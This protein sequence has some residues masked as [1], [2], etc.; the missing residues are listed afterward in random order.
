MRAASKTPLAKQ[1]RENISFFRRVGRAAFTEAVATPPV[2]LEPQRPAPPPHPGLGRQPVDDFLPG[3]DERCTC[4]T[5]AWCGA[6]K[7]D[8]VHDLMTHGMRLDRPR[9][10]AIWRDAQDSRVG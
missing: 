7:G 4:R 9:A 2:A 1:L 8:V 10:E 3:D 5:P 6:T